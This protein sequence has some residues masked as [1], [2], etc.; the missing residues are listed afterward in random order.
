MA[1]EERAHDIRDL[2]RHRES[3]PKV[4][5]PVSSS[6]GASVYTS[7]ACLDRELWRVMPVVRGYLCI[8]YILF[9][10]Q[11]LDSHVTGNFP[12][13]SESSLTLSRGKGQVRR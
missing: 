13:D 11:E 12:A 1:V 9:W 6:I 3:L 2:D 10:V 8:Q 4:T 7:V 5:D